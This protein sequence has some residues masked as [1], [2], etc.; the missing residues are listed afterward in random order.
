MVDARSSAPA[1]APRGAR[2]ALVIAAAVVPL[3][4]VAAQD[5]ADQAEVAE[6]LVPV[7]VRDAKGR[8]VADLE[9]QK[10]RLF[11]DGI[12][13]PIRSFWREGGLPLALTFLV[14]TSGSMGTRRLARAS[15]AILEFVRYLKPEDEVCL[16]TFG[17]DEVKRRLPFGTDPSLI[18]RIL[19]PLSGF[20]TTAIFDVLTI[21]P[22]VMEGARNSRR[23]ILL[24]TDGV[25]TASRFS[26]EDAARVV[27][28]LAD[29]LYVFGIEPPPPPDG[30]AETYEALLTRFATASGG[31]Y[32]RI[33]DLGAL[34]TASQGLRRELTQRY[35]IAFAPSGVGTVK[36]RSLSVSVEG[37]FQV[38][39]RQGYRGTLP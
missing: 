22:R 24:F 20:G 13:F 32:L 33:D 14:D 37:P 31:R 15:E 9:R 38:V 7:T 39:A 34:R 26:S 6:V 28:S 10:F 2:L 16:I 29:P 30:S 35:I 8:L 5:F 21:T 36:L 4:P 27:E 19:E 25:D 1:A 18:R 12:E 11:V 3:A 17:A 23:A